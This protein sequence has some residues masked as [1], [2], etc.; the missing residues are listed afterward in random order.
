MLEHVQRFHRAA[1]KRAHKYLFRG[2]K[3]PH[4]QWVWDHFAH[5]TDAN[6]SISKRGRDPRLKY[7]LD[8]VYYRDMCNAQFVLTPTDVYAWSYRF[9]E[10]IMCRAIPILHDDEVDKFA[11][12]FRVYR[13]SEKHV[14]REDWVEHNLAQLRAHHTLDTLPGPALVP[15]HPKDHRVET[16]SHNTGLFHTPP[17][18]F[19]HQHACVVWMMH[20]ESR[21][22]WHALLGV[23]WDQGICKMLAHSNHFLVERYCPGQQRAHHIYDRILYSYRTLRTRVHDETIRARCLLAGNPFSGCNAGHDLSILLNYVVYW[24]EHR[25]ALDK[26]VLLRSSTWLPD[27]NLTLLYSVVDRADVLFLEPNRIYHFEHVHVP[28]QLFLHIARPMHIVHELR[29]HVLEAVPEEERAALRR[30]KLVMLKC[31]RNHQVMRRDT[32]YVC[33]QL[34]GKLESQGYEYVNPEDVPVCHLAYMLMHATHVVSSWGGVLYVNM[35]FINLEAHIR[36][37][38]LAN[39][40]RSDAYAYVMRHAKAVRVP[41][42]QLDAHPKW[43]TQVLQQINM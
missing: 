22:H 29:K 4:K 9:F 12:R 14:W 19:E 28:P 15:W 32:A 3:T 30:K 27:N 39:Q 5:R 10:A 20:P 36:V 24:R 13:H 26:F 41:G 25:A 7:K 33:E 35:I 11:H 18:V 21:F 8:D 37:L 23:V 31:H 42:T 43:T 40:G 38:Y 6:V 34:L 16:H 2:L 17:G 1:D